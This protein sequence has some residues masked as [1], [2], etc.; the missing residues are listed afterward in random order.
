MINFKTLFLGFLL[1][2]FSYN[3][4]AQEKFSDNLSLG[5]NHGIGFI[6]PEYQFLNYLSRDYTRTT[7]FSLKKETKGNTPWETLY[8]NPEY[9]LRFVYS[10]LGNESALGSVYGLYPYIGIQLVQFKKFSLF[11]ET[12]IGIS[13]VSKT[14]DLE[15]NYLNVAVGSHY[16]I[17]FNMRMSLRFKVNE[18]LG[19]NA[20]L[21]F[22][23]FSNANT[24]APNLGI[25][26]IAWNGGLYYRLGKEGEK[27]NSEFPDQEKT[28]KKELVLNIGGKRSRA[29][30][31]EYYRTQ[32]I[33]FEFRKNCFKAL[34]LG[35]GA[36][37]FYDD[38]VEDQLQKQEKKF[39]GKD[40]YQTGFHLSQTFIYSHFSVGIQQGLYVGLKEKVEGYSLYNRMVLKYQMHNRLSFRFSM[41]SHLH[42]LDYPE[43]GIGYKW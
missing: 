4:S 20:G 17:H 33:S 3:S 12:G 1:F 18:K 10:D 9:G 13:Y 22:D 39:E 35:V 43:I 34:H 21:S 42:I 41:K 38:S 27:K 14:F 31:K 28:W 6:L 29:L 40:N 16:N 23:H 26:Y 25:N 32:S 37:L 8:G 7:E 15:E 2:S 36:D 24:S 11:N 30:S 5:M 19:L